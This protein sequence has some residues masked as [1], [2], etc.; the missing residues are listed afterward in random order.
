[1]KVLEI[2]KETLAKMR[3]YSAAVTIGDDLVANAIWDEKN[4][5]CNWLGRRDIVDS[6]IAA[7]SVRTAAMSPEFY[8]GSVGISLFLMEL[9]HITRNNSYYKTALGG[10][11]RSVAYLQQNEFPASPI[12]FYAGDLGTLYVASRFIEIEPELE[13]DL[14]NEIAYLVQKIENGIQVKHSLDVIGGNA[15]A[16]GPLFRLAQKHGW[17]I[18]E[19]VAKECADEILELARW[20][21]EICFW[22]SPKIH[23]V[24]LDSPPLTG[25]SHGCSGIALGLLKAYEQ[26]G[27]LKYLTHA[28]GAFAFENA[29]FNEDENNWIDTRYPHWMNDGKVT[30]TFRSAWCHGA[31]GNVLAYMDAAGIDTERSGFLSDRTERAVITTRKQLLEKMEEPHKD[32]TLCHGVL[33]LSDILLTYGS[34]MKDAEVIQMAYDCSEKYLDLFASVLD[35][36]SGIHAGGFSPSLMTGSAG[37]GLHFLRLYSDNEIPSVLLIT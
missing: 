32:A 20:K 28:R 14:E 25:F 30:G 37:I 34:R 13:S 22:D 17:T 15:G 9:Y 31:P 1:M 4:A 24:E 16:I 19:R 2:E 11:L 8:S 6:E 27:E 12:S 3:F 5:T 33:G 7:Y 10:W 35:M 23:G 21:D 18:C 29:L 36:P 26:T